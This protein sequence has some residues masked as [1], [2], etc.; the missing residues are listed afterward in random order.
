MKRNVLHRAALAVLAAGLGCAGP[1]WS[2]AATN[3]AP[4]AQAA[5]DENALAALDRMGQALRGLKSFTVLSDASL[6]VVLETD[7]KVE[8]D[9][10]VTYKVQQPDRMFVDF[11]GDRIHRQ[12]FYDGARLTVYSP[13]LNYYATAQNEGKTLGEL[14]VSAAVN[15]GIEFPLTDLFFWGTP[16][17]PRDLIKSAMF[18]GPGN[19]GGEKVDHFALR[20]EGI[21]WQ[22]WLSRRSSLPRKIVITDLTD[23]ARPQY[24][25]RLFWDTTTPVDGKVFAFQP[26]AG[27]TR[28][29][30]VPREAVASVDAQ[31]N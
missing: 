1:A 7:E 4:P 13:R 10:K 30:L 6:D 16:L 9:A 25:A 18:V 17:V 14:A 26:P 20:Q 31:E 3:A 29:D 27:A 19:V 5:L 23:A 21:D 28:I 11:V 22:I 8:L 24:Q 12:L 15:Y 2:Q